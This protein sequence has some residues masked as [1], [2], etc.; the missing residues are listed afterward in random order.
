MPHA[1]AV[2]SVSEI[3]GIMPF[4]ILYA[5][6]VTNGRDGAADTPSWGA[7]LH[8]VLVTVRL[9]AMVVCRRKRTPVRIE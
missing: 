4:A 2:R 1:S 8:V 7:S 5:M 3:L 9:I 6:F